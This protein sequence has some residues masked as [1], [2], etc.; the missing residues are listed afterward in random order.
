MINQKRLSLSILLTV[1][2][3]MVSVSQ[4][5]CFPSISKMFKMNKQLQ[6]EGYYM[7]EFEFKMLGIVYNLDHGRY[8][9]AYSQLTK[10]NKQ[11]KTREGLIKIPKFANKSEEMEFYL[12]LQNPKTGAFMDDTYPYCTYTGPTGNVLI[13]LDALAKETGQPIKLKYPLKYMDEINTPEKL[14]K[15]LDDVATVGWIGNKFPQTSFHFTRDLLSLFY[16][17]N[18]LDL[19]GLYKVTPEWRSALLGWFYEQQDSVSGVW[20]PKSKSGKL[21]RHDTMNTASILKSFIDE[22]GNNK[23]QAYPLRYRDQL[24][25]TILQET[26]FEIPDDTDL[27][28]WHEW[29]LNTSKSIRMLTRCLWSDLSEA[30][31]QKT[32]VLI[33]SFIK[34]KYEKLYIKEEGSFSLYPNSEHA[35]LDGSGG[36]LTIYKEVGAFSGEKYLSMW[37]N[38][39]LQCKNLGDLATLEI[40]ENDIRANQILMQS[41]SIRIYSEEPDSA[42]FTRNVI[43]VFYPQ[44]TICLDVMELLPGMKDWVTKTSQS[45]GNWTSKEDLMMNISGTGINYTPIFKESLPINEMNQCLNTN[46][47]VIL[48]GFDEL[49]I[50]RC[51]LIL[52]LKG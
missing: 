47:K 23:N 33:K 20:G 15:Y 22:E 43:T 41:N 38:P 49:Q 31:K 26:S 13:H 37:G 21:R 36:I 52:I 48:I 42:K 5:Y 40:T 16:E 32:V 12:N 29:N 34:T 1:L 2:F 7:A 39:D 27:E 10:L 51:K 6:E 35:T 25:N 4:A 14:R 24:A 3:L 46:K 11:L 8:C 50:P 45:L 19:H 18:T 28:Y 30:S 44:K 9:K 17:D